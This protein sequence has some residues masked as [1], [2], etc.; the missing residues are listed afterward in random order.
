MRN[1]FVMS[2]HL[3]DRAERL[4]RFFYTYVRVFDP[5]DTDKALKKNYRNKF[6]FSLAVGPMP[7]F[8][9]LA[10][11]YPLFFA[12]QYVLPLMVL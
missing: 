11:P 8:F 4:D 3:K 12:Q 5:E 7:L 10:F 9:T 6:L 2:Q 1:L